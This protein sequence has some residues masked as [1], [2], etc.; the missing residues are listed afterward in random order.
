MNSS[1]QGKT[2]ETSKSLASSSGNNQTD[3]MPEGP[4][5]DATPTEAEHVLEP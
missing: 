5:S 3:A 4:K 2:E 1:P